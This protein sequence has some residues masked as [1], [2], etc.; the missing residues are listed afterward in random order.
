MAPSGR[1]APRGAP[2]RRGPGRPRPR[3][4]NLDVVPENTRVNVPKC[5]KSAAIYMAIDHR[6]VF[7]MR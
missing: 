1:V 6:S 5:T 7:F 2:W 4:E 3:H